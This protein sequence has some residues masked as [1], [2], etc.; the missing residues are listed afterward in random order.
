[1]EYQNLDLVIQPQLGAAHVYAVVATG[2][3]GASFQGTLDLSAHWDRLQALCDQVSQ[4]ATAVRSG[5]ARTVFPEAAV[6][7]E[8]E[9][10]ETIAEE[11][12]RLLFEAGFEGEVAAVL[13]SVDRSARARGEGLRI[14]L[15]LQRAPELHRL[16]WEYLNDGKAFLATDARVPIVR[17]LDKAEAWRPIGVTGA[18]RIL[19]VVSA[20]QDQQPLD[21]ARECE[22]MR[23]ALAGL[24]ES[25]RVVLDFIESGRWSAL[26]DALSPGTKKP[27]YHVLHFIGH[28]GTSREGRGLV[29]FCDASGRSVA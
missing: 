29:Y 27:A 24:V 7:P 12:G 16:P 23:N 5:G 19:T 14:R 13:R 10:V 20:P 28:G 22:Q 9:A 6:D 26:A 21:T 2:S 8:A 11:L 3:D 17:Y 4:R 15:R 1:M 25:G 18:L